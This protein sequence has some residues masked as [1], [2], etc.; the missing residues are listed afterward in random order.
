[1]RYIHIRSSAGDIKAGLI[2]TVQPLNS[3]GIIAAIMRV[4]DDKRHNMLPCLLPLLSHDFSGYA[5]V[6]FQSVVFLE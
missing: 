1:M 3:R 2:L 6:D 4:R 5:Q